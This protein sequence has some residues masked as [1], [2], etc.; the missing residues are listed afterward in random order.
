MR[1]RKCQISGSQVALQLSCT[2]LM[3][4]KTGCF[5]TYYMLGTNDKFAP[6]SQ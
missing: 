1:Q 2:V 3:A 6:R 4:L 5:E